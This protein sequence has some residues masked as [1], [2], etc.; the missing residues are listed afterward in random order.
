MRISHLDHVGTELKV[1]KSEPSF[2]HSVNKSLN[3]LSNNIVQSQN[4]VKPAVNFK[5]ETIIKKSPASIGNMS[6]II[7]DRKVLF[8]IKIKL[9]DNKF[10]QL[11][12]HEGD[13]LANIARDF[14]KNHNLDKLNT[15][16]VEKIL[17]DTYVHIRKEN[18]I[19][20]KF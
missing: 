15:L 7:E 8:S 5:S 17:N 11:T 12:V 16:N 13:S 14:A 3:N 4:N 20:K 18:L 6:T 9:Y 19:K 10:G 2:L 1:S